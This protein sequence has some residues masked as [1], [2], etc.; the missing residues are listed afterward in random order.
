MPNEEENEEPIQETLDFNSPSFTFVPKET[1]E[2]RQKGYYLV[3]VSCELQHAVFI[4]PDKIMV[5]V[6]E[7]GSPIIKSRK[8]LGMA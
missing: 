1:H 8:E 2:W 6:D 3:C 4:G 7:K 5:G